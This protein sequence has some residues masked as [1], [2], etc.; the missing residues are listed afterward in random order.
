MEYFQDEWNPVPVCKEIVIQWEETV[1]I[2][3]IRNY[4]LH[5]LFLVWK[6]REERGNT[7][8]EIKEWIKIC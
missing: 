2:C 1:I 5:S 4:L 3:L 7:W 6:V 8:S